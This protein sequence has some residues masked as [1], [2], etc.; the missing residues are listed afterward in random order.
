MENFEKP[1]LISLII[2]LGLILYMR[3]LKSLN[4]RKNSN[5]YISIDGYDVKGTDLEIRY[6]S[7][8]AID[9]E[10]LFKDKSNKEIK[11][12]SIVH[13]EKGNY[14]YTISIS[15]ITEETIRFHCET[16][17]QKIDKRIYLSV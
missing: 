11:K 4:R 1:M 12:A 13:T 7:Q 14:V 5:K 2:V 8:E 3:L 17:N 10:F 6:S 9:T 15:G 16:S